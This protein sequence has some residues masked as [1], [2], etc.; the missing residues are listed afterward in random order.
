MPS[1]VAYYGRFGSW[2]Q[3]LEEAGFTARNKRHTDTELLEFMRNKIEKL[4]RRPSEQ[5]IN[6]DRNMPSVSTYR[7]HFGTLQSVFKLLR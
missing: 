2:A 5:E 1:L 4:G 3:A 7:N 6:A